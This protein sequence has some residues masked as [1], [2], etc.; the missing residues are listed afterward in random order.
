MNEITPFNYSDLS[1]TEAAEL[2]AVTARIRNRLTRQ[3]KDIIE[4]GRDLI[5]VKSKLEHG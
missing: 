1:A 4:T 2:E 5:E 3:V